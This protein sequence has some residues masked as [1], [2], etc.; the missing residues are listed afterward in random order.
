MD[1][2]PQCEGN[3]VAVPVNNWTVHIKALQQI[4][5]ALC[6]IQEVLFGPKKL[7]MYSQK[8]ALNKNRNI[9]CYTMHT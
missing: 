4:M 8:K 2:D 3:A 9:S 7:L 5:P 6:W 1:G